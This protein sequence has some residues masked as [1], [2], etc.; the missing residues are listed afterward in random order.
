MIYKI[1]RNIIG[2]FVFIHM[3]NIVIKRLYDTVY[4]YGHLSVISTDKT[5]FIECIIL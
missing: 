3:N 4:S 1:I 5:P 2:H